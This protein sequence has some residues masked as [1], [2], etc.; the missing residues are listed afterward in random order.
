MH[1]VN[2]AKCKKMGRSIW[3]HTLGMRD[4]NKTAHGKDGFLRLPAYF[5]LTPLLYIYMKLHIYRE[6]PNSTR[7]MLIYSLLWF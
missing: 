3:F 7:T 1:T 5:I 6:F 4:Y 2:I